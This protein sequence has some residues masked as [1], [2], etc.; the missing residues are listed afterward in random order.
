MSY[1][2]VTWWVLP[3]VLVAAHGCVAPT[4]EER[5]ASEDPTVRVGAVYEL[6]GEAGSEADVH[7]IHL[8]ADEDEG[9]RFFAAA[10]LGRRTGKRFDYQAQG[11]L[12]ERAHSVRRWVDWYV[13]GHPGTEDK[14]TDLDGWL[15]A[16]GVGAGQA[17]SGQGG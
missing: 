9:V 15:T 3:A 8:L 14:F 2:L 12:R 7:L 6:A 10:C 4:L 13:A 16:L 1:R 11:S 17:E 5:L